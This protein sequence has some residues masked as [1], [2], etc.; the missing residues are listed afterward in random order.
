M[1]ESPDDYVNI[2]GLAQAPQRVA[3]AKS[4]LRL[5]LREKSYINACNYCNGRTY[6]DPEIVPGIQTK[7]VLVYKKYER[8]T[9]VKQPIE[10]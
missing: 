7:A 2:R 9:E 6:G 8:A 1:P 3:E 10:A 4:A 5:F